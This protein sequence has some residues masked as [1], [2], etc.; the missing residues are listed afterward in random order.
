MITASTP[1]GRHVTKQQ[2]VYASLRTAILRCELRPG[3]RL[4]IDE[5][6]RRL[7]T[8]II[9]VREA[10]RL[11]ESEA[12]VVNIAHVGAT[13]APISRTSVMD[14]FTVL[15]GLESVSTRTAA[16]RAGAADFETLYALL[17]AMEDAIA[18]GEHDEWAALNTRFHLVM[19]AL[20]GMPMLEGMLVRALDHWERV[21]RYFFQGVLAHRTAVAQRE[22]RLIV[23]Q[24]KARDLAELERTVRIHNQSALAA[25]TEYLDAH[26]TRGDS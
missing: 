16:Q 15:E 6:A 24:M 11:L 1:D 18:R 4:I 21:R 23:N 10:I 13:V 17:E 14:T 3:E 26:P 22:H 5:L 9:P 12:F 20:A 25:Y 8:S 7:D 2:Y 19:A